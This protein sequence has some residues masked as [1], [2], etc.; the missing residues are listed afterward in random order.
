MS[1]FFGLVAIGLHNTMN[2]SNRLC[3]DHPAA[4]TRAISCSIIHSAV[5]I[6]EK[7]LPIVGTESEGIGVNVDTTMNHVSRDRIRNIKDPGTA[8]LQAYL[9]DDSYRCAM[10]LRS[11]LTLVETL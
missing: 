10:S 8:D 1:L 2:I 11:E 6:N 9:D 5:F 3:F 4:V 7:L